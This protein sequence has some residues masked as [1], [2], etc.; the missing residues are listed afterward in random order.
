MDCLPPLV[1][2]LARERDNPALDDRRTCNGYTGL[3][4]SEGRKR[5]GWHRGFQGELEHPK[6]KKQ[7]FSGMAATLRL[8]ITRRRESRS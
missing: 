2:S 4:G 6:T 8:L 3:G 1:G 7:I 5:R